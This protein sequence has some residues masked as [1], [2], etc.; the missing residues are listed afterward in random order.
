MERAEGKTIDLQDNVTLAVLN[1]ICAMVFGS[2]YDLVDPEF[3]DL[4]ELNV[5]MSRLFINGPE[6][7]NTSLVKVFTNKYN[8]GCQGMHEF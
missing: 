7:T 5:M 4:V 2:R 6:I 8:G 1:I 3:R